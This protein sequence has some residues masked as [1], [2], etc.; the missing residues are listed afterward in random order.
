MLSVKMSLSKEKNIA[1][2]LNAIDGSNLRS[3]AGQQEWIKLVNDF[4][5]RD[6]VSSSDEENVSD[7]DETLEPETTSIHDGIDDEDNNLDE[8]ENLSEPV[9]DLGEVERAMSSCEAVSV[10]TVNE[11]R[12]D[13]IRKIRE[14][15]CNGCKLNNGEPCFK[16]FN[17]DFVHD[18]RLSMASLTE[19]EKDLVLLG[20]IS[21]H[22]QNSDFTRC[23]K[24]KTQRERQHQRTEHYVNG[25]RVCRE[26][27]KFL[28][29]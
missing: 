26:T 28:H 25:R 22:F 1:K 10:G 3:A 6:P 27:F 9:T 21:C 7:E 16:S 2:A 19:Y 23:S 8:D 13:E 11:N 12:D 14:F 17:E 15:S 20:K 4:F 18:L 5:G 29:W 24:K